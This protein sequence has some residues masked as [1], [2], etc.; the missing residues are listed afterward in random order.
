MV[1][2][3]RTFYE[4][5]K[6]QSGAKFGLAMYL[7]PKTKVVKTVVMGEGLM[8]TEIQAGR[9]DDWIDFLE[10]CLFRIELPSALTQHQPTSNEGDPSAYLER[11]ASQL[12]SARSQGTV[13]KYGAQV[14]LRHVHSG[15]LLS[16]SLLK[17]GIEPGTF[18]VSLE[19]RTKAAMSCLTLFPENKLQKIGEPIK[20]GDK[21][22]I[23]FQ[24]GG[25]KYF[26]QLHAPPGS[27]VMEIN[28]SH[29]S[30]AWVFGLYADFDSSVDTVTCSTPLRIRLVNSPLHL[31]EKRDDSQV[32]ACL[33]SDPRD[34]SGL[35]LLE[36]SDLLQ[37]GNLHY[38]QRFFLKNAQSG[39][40]LTSD[41]SLQRE[42]P[43]IHSALKLP[44]PDA[45]S[46]LA[47]VAYNFPLIFA[48]QNGQLAAKS[49]ERKE[50]ILSRLV[51]YNYISD[52]TNSAVHLES[53]LMVE[54]TD[55]DREVLFEFLSIDRL[56]SEFY[57]QVA[58]VLPKVVSFVITLQS[59]MDEGRL[60][61]WDEDILTTGN[62]IS[63]VIEKLKAG[64]VVSVG[65]AVVESRQNAIVG[66]RFHTA[67]I[68]LALKIAQFR[69]S[70]DSS[71]L[72]TLLKRLFIEIWQFLIEV[73][74]D[75]KLAA[76]YV[77]QSRDAMCK[78]VKLEQ[79][80]IGSLLTEVYR[81]TDPD[82]PNYE[83]DFATWCG[84]LKT[85]KERNIEKQTVFI[86]LIQG[87][88]EVGDTPKP[89]YQR[90]VLN[91]LFRPGTFQVFKLEKRN[92]RFYVHFA[93]RDPG[94]ETDSFE[95]RHPGLQVDKELL[96]ETG[97][98]YV[99]LTVLRRKP[100]YVHYVYAAMCLVSTLCKGEREDG[101]LIARVYLGLTPALVFSMIEDLSLHI[102]L[103]EACLILSDS[104]TLS[105]P[106]A[107]PSLSRKENDQCYISSELH[108]FA[109]FPAEFVDP[110]DGSYLQTLEVRTC[111][112]ETLVLW[113][114]MD[115]PQQVKGAELTDL[116]D[117]LIAG[118]KLAYT[119]LDYEKCSSLYVMC[120]LRTLVYLLIALSTS[121]DAPRF[122]RRHWTV[123]ALK[124]LDKESNSRLEVRLRRNEL[125]RLLVDLLLAICAHIRQE[126]C[127][128]LLHI[129][130][131][132]SDWQV[133]PE[134]VRMDTE[135]INDSAE[136]KSRIRRMTARAIEFLAKYGEMLDD[137]IDH[138]DSHPAARRSVLTHAPGLKT[139]LFRAV[140]SLKSVPSNLKDRIILLLKRLFN[141]ENRIGKF[142]SNVDIITDKNTIAQYTALKTLKSRLRI[143]DLSTDCRFELTTSNDGHALQSLCDLLESVT[144]FINP[145][146]QQ[147][148]AKT[149]KM[150]NIMR[151][152]GFHRDFMGLW[153]LCLQV[154]TAQ[155]A[156][157]KRRWERIRALL[158]IF[159][160][161]FCRRNERNCKELRSLFSPSHYFLTVPQ[162]AELIREVSDYETLSNDTTS[163]LIS[164]LLS[165][166]D[167][168]LR[169]FAF[170]RFIMF[171]K[172]GNPKADVQN[173]AGRLIAEKLFICVLAP[174]PDLTAGLIELQALTCCLNATCVVQSRNILSLRD[175]KSMS[176]THSPQLHSAILPFLYYVYLR[177]EGGCEPS[178]HTSTILDILQNTLRI[179]E[180]VMDRTMDLIDAGKMGLTE[181][182]FP[183]ENP[184]L[185]D[186]MTALQPLN[187]LRTSIRLLFTHGRHLPKGGV[188][189]YL[190]RILE[191]ILFSPDLAVPVAQDFLGKLQTYEGK[192][193]KME[194]NNPE[195]EFAP[196]KSAVW[197]CISKLEV[198]IGAFDLNDTFHPKPVPGGGKSPRQIRDEEVFLSEKLRLFTKEY[199]EVVL[200]G[201]SEDYIKELVDNFK[202]VAFN[203]EFPKGKV[204]KEAVAKLVTLLERVQRLFLGTRN[205]RLYFKFL[206]DLVPDINSPSDLR[207]KYVFNPV[208]LKAE[209]IEEAL[210]ALI[211][212]EA[213]FAANSTL[214][215]LNKLLEE[216]TKGFQD[217]FQGLLVEK[218]RAYYLFTRFARDIAAMKQVI[219][220]RA[221]SSQSRCLITPSGTMVTEHIV[222]EDIQ[223]GSQERY[224]INIMVFLQLCCDNCNLDFQNYIRAQQAS[225][226]DVDLVSELALF[227][228]EL[229]SVSDYVS[230]HK[231]AGKMLMKAF[232]ALL[233]FVTGPCPG[234]Q[235]VLGTNV[236]L[237]LAINKLIKIVQTD[238]KTV[239]RKIHTKI[240]LFLHTLLEG[241]A[242]EAVYQTI[243]S[244]MDL[245]ALRTGLETIYS[246]HI[247]GNESSLLLETAAPELLD[248]VKVCIL[249]ALFLLKVSDFSEAHLELKRFAPPSK[250]YTYFAQ[251]AGYI[252][253]E[254]Q[255]VIQ[256]HY[257]PI[258]FKCKFLTSTSRLAVLMDVKRSSHQKKIE[259]FL[260]RVPGLMREM[261]HQ[262]AL[263][264]NRSLKSFISQWQLFAQASFFLVFLI[265]LQ[266]LVTFEGTLHESINNHPMNVIYIAILGVLQLILYMISFLFNMIE[267]FPSKI[268]DRPVTQA[269]EISRLPHLMHNE[270]QYVRSLYYE[271]T[272]FT[273]SEAASFESSLRTIRQNMDF[274]YNYIYFLI[275]VAALYYPLLY[276]FLMLDLVKQNQELINVLKSITVN[277]WQLLITL[278]LGFIIIFLFSSYAFMF[279]QEFYVLEAGVKCDTLLDCFLSTLH[280]GVRAG[281]GIGDVLLMPTHDHK[282]Y[283]SRFT[284][285]MLFYLIIIII[286]MNIIFGIIID[287]FA[288]LRSQREAVLRD[289]NNVCYVCGLD[290]GEIERKGRGWMY[291]FMIEHSPLA[292]L[293][294][295][296]YLIETPI[297]DCAGIEKYVK[298]KFQRR[299]ATFMPTSSFLI[300]LNEAR[301]S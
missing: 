142:L 207:K 277:A 213:S 290:R 169:A 122:S 183:K 60:E 18:K 115:M 126:K 39:R 191:G 148:S 270:S 145:R 24:D 267:Y 170:I 110:L 131:T 210:D 9:Y 297:V 196:L 132:E 107:Q 32:R 218:E 298:E 232:A 130:I 202:F 258:P 84:R 255:G 4:V 234:N 224:I 195:L 13:L 102:K 56:E 238:F 240:I 120:L 41:L 38:E 239:G 141:E 244:F 109:P 26:L 43:D 276:P 97:E 1:S 14:Q 23:M 11:K 91:H 230:S 40:Y 3:R 156:A 242:Q 295:L 293:S 34:F 19:P 8:D 99:N 113:M 86:R 47:M 261:E 217:T 198:F 291:H 75:N 61:D 54:R 167:E 33:R 124:F 237:V 63:R 221:S 137:T 80:L 76:S 79:R 12:A 153:T 223:I 123:H 78:M 96:E 175:L 53:D 112:R 66:L 264:R 62:R 231:A 285:D 16:L 280:M 162:Y 180:E 200:A 269:I 37:G 57:L 288:Q 74:A 25:L 273:T 45:F 243:L 48:F 72:K 128:K 88:V 125:F 15:S 201:K 127:L 286:L 95:Q 257:F 226:A 172:R 275:S 266:L 220:E 42:H 246:N 265:N 134:K 248:K 165:H 81:L 253:V 90:V 251:F 10:L 164:Y 111:L 263:S 35:W 21:V 215:F 214:E 241:N 168:E 271:L 20:Y 272:T 140:L 129:C 58:K 296:V 160:L 29:N 284:F 161:Y 256:P 282:D 150:Q 173:I 249:Q 51:P 71:Q 211:R 64:I 117:Y 22:K 208:F 94:V 146:K 157:V 83:Q 103:R 190:P 260:S 209:V 216:Q 44:K 259:D 171:D 136:D 67:L 262:Q 299:D 197:D 206:R 151:H 49:S 186:E 289:I 68:N 30:S 292:Y 70:A 149:R 227:V 159:L 6:I 281:G 174:Q 235:L 179:A 143:T 73:V 118:L 229:S 69:L 92:K 104:L 2:L 31:A 228:I 155:S 268:D 158:A 147:N 154:P 89:E 46:S 212:G 82:M 77:E 287:T 138:A 274:Y 283:W 28:G 250:A 178:S 85:L 204:A 55:I 233:D 52:E 181:L 36:R 300:R 278:C 166:H 193:G 199:H 139:Y 105:S 247:S 108:D 101:R 98:E 245:G 65:S 116:L 119:L 176:Q 133:Q 279:L 87:I 59:H 135:E 236:Q 225:L 152:L 184:T 189:D 144:N 301:D 106:P 5:T 187:P 177:A 27:S 203:G 294:F 50:E 194:E 114:Q 219:V 7:P 17:A 163:Q 252:E 182:V 93:R 254:R 205:R 222:D 188:L 121:Q 100:A 192:I 185:V